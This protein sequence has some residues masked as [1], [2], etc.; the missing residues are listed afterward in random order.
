MKS[1]KDRS[2]TRLP[3]PVSRAT[4]VAFIGCGREDVSNP[5]VV[6]DADG[7]RPQDLPRPDR[8]DLGHPDEALR[9]D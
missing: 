2:A 6:L 4:G 7:V 3:L 8:Y 5:R 1:S 9:A